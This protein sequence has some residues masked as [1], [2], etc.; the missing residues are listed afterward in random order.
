MSTRLP[1]L[2]SLQAFA[3]VGR[4]LSVKAAAETLGITASAVSHRL[5]LLEAELQV[6]LFERS[7]SGLAFTEVGREYFYIVD[8]A[9]ARISEGTEQL[10]QGHLVDTLVV[11]VVHA[12]AANWIFPNLAEF[13]ARHP[14]LTLSFHPKTVREYNTT[15]PRDLRGRAELRW[16]DGNWPGFHCEPVLECRTFP[17]CSPRLLKGPDAI[18]TPADLA[19]HVWIHITLYPQAWPE[20]LAEAG[21][22]G[23]R[24]KQ[25]MYVEDSELRRLAAV[26]GLGVAL[27]VDI[28][29]QR[30]L[31][32]G[33]LVAPFDIE[34]RALEGYF[35]VCHP[36]DREDHRIRA[37]A[38]WL[39]DLAARTSRNCANP[40]APPS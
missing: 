1:S 3:A 12:L 27:A 22:P 21:L 14:H 29:V 19:R 32:T 34:H 9:F 24:P 26:H 11:N 30:D 5:R 38:D 23:L 7:G 16:G 6:V 37:F 40:P 20:W 28:L 4:S 35:L 17:V 31:E 10:R 15:T 25:N 39:Q 8:A 13:R 18:S 36:D 33:A 2:K